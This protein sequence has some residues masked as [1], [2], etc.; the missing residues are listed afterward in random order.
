MVSKCP[1]GRSATSVNKQGVPVCAKHKS[2]KVKIPLCPEC[3]LVMALRNGKF[4][5]FW[6]CM[7][8]PNCNGVRKT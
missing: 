2:Y 4:G 3:G 1:C 5:A 8:Y 6:G 7:A